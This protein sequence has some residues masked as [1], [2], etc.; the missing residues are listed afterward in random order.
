MID[1]R[2]MQE[3]IKKA[4]LGQELSA[5]ELFIDLVQEDPNNKLA[6]LWLIGLL[7]DRDDLILA[8]E[9]VLRIDPTETR[10]RMRLDELRRIEK[11]EKERAENAALAKVDKL[12][13]DGNTESALRH[14]RKITKENNKSEIAWSMLAKYTN[15]LVEKER[16]L[17]RL[18]A[19]DPANKEK[20]EALKRARYY[21]ENPLELAVS[22][23][24]NGEI[25]KA[26]KVYESVSA[27]AKGRSEW[28]RLF[29]EINRLRGLKEEKIVH[30][31]PKVTIARLTL[32]PPLLFLFMLI[33][34]VGYDFRYIS[35][36]MGV[37]F[38]LVIVGAF[39]VALS[40][41]GSE[42]RIWKKLGSVGGRG[43]KRLRMLVGAAG[44]TLMFLSFALLG[45]EAYVRWLPLLP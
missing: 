18:Y 33:A 36:L 45:L 15:D 32:G 30:V 24:E 31:S 29:R 4:K 11:V 23:E 22:Y 35:L 6:W 38:L 3:A 21:R 2:R 37:E 10:V 27:K 41:A 42:N 7:D 9:E 25:E 19:F 13:S 43:S 39:L 1:N 26:I 28:D 16:A 14:L 8:C 44:V 34:Q 40:T 20:K 5:R 17:A 12:L